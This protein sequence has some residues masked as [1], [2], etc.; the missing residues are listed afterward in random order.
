MRIGL[1]DVIM[2]AAA[3]LFPFPFVIY[4]SSLYFCFD[5]YYFVLGDVLGDPNY[6][7]VS[8]TVYI[9]CLAIQ[10]FLT[11]CVFEC[12]RT[13]SLAGMIII[14]LIDVLQEK[15]QDMLA[16]KIKDVD[17]LQIS[18]TLF[19]H[20]SIICKNF[21]SALQ[22]GITLSIT[23]CF[24]AIVV[25]GWVVIKA[26]H[27]IPFFMYFMLLIAWAVVFVCLIIVLTLYSHFCERS[28]YLTWRLKFMAEKIHAEFC[29]ILG[30]RRLR[31]LKLQSRAFIPIRIYYYPFLVIDREF[32]RTTAGNL[33][34]RLFDAILI[35]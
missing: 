25:G 17:T 3:A 16:S 9:L 23:M 22:E 29:T 31:I 26:R 11:F 5:P 21:Q 20:L 24:W 13:I 12:C 28:D 4:F 32:C 10:A 33:F 15:F 18:L 14:Q 2:M 1:L 35:F 6:E 30:R 34:D 19:V 8:T 27:L 7:R